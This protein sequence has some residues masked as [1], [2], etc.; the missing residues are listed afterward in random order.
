MRKVW[1]R[2]QGRLSRKAAALI[3]LGVVVA[4]VVVAGGMVIRFNHAVHAAAPGDVEPASPE[5]H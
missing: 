3:I 2:R 1:G 4:G 5:A